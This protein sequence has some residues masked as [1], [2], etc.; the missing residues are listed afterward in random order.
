MRTL[1][2]RRFGDSGDT[3][4]TALDGFLFLFETVEDYSTVSYSNPV[5]NEINH[6]SSDGTG[7][8]KVNYE[9]SEVHEYA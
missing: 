8:F 5:W 3:T 6:R 9:Y 7:G 2:V 1:Y 4:R